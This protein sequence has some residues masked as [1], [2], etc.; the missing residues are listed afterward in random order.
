MVYL[1]TIWFWSIKTILK[2]QLLSELLIELKIAAN[3]LYILNLQGKTF[4]LQEEPE[5]F[6][7]T[8]ESSANQEVAEVTKPTGIRKLKKSVSSEKD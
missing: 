6:S 8:E 2:W 7:S 4:T 5:M 3:T 1:W